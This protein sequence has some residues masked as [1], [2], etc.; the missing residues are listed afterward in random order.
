M[1]ESITNRNILVKIGATD[2]FSRQFWRRNLVIEPLELKQRRPSYRIPLKK[3]WEVKMGSET[4]FLYPVSSFLFCLGRWNI[5][6]VRAGTQSWMGSLPS[7]WHVPRSLALHGDF[8]GDWGFP[9][10][11]RNWETCLVSAIWFF[12]YLGEGFAWSENYF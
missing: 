12:L 6:E 10:Q 3:N 7:I 8:F 5:L 9:H 1:I 11:F 2:V 4:I